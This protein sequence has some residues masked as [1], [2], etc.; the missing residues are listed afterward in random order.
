MPDGRM[1]DGQIVNCTSG[2]NSKQGGQSWQ[3]CHH[4]RQEHSFDWC[5]RGASLS[6]VD[7]KHTIKEESKQVY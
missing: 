6:T 3:Q 7:D 1:P 4:S 5:V 2:M